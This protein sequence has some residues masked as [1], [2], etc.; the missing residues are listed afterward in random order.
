[1]TSAKT[2]R[3]IRALHAQG[4]SVADIHLITGVSADNLRGILTVP[5]DAT[6]VPPACE[7]PDS[8]DALFD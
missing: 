5:A 8:M 3:H 1:M 4:C 7:H 6:P 2:I